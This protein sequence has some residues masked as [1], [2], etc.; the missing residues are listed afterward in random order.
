[1]TTPSTS[2]AS[3]AD[4]PLPYGQSINVNERYLRWAEQQPH[5]NDRSFCCDVLVPLLVHQTSEP[6]A[7]ANLSFTGKFGAALAAQT[8]PNFRG[9]TLVGFNTESIMAAD[10]KNFQFV[11]PMPADSMASSYVRYVQLAFPNGMMFLF[12][13]FTATPE[14]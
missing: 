2:S 4:E 9:Y 7:A 3:A 12:K 5:Q 13:T 10:M 8:M 6:V 1:M 14:D 11:M